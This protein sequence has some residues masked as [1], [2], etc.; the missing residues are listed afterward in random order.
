MLLKKILTP[1]ILIFSLMLGLALTPLVADVASAASYTIQGGADAAKGSDQPVELFGS[2]GV[3]RTIT[4][5]LLFI[6]GAISVIMIIVG[7]L[8][9]VLSGGDST[10]IT[11]AKNTILYAIIGLIVA[12]LAYAM[13]D[14]VIN[15]FAISGGAGGGAEI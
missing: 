5:V 6:V 8:R 1:S 12:L 11:G 2:T 3:F 14:F 15:S 10:H 13:I 9:Y 7:G 4:N